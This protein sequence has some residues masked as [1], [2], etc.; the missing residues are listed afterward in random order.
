MLA[1]GGKHPSAVCIFGRIAGYF[2]KNQMMA[3]GVFIPGYDLARYY[4]VAYLPGD[5]EL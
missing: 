5:D 4:N 2:L 3:G 1:A